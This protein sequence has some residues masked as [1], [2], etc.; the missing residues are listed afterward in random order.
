[1]RLVMRIHRYLSCATA[2]LLLF[3]AVSG[4]WQVFRLQDTK[5]DGSYTAPKPLEVLSRV[6]KVERMG[7]ASATVFKIAILAA[8]TV[9]VT[10]AVLGIVIGIRLTQPR[11]LAWA[12][13]AGGI[14]IPGAL[15][16][17]AL[18][19]PPPPRTPPAAAAPQPADSVAER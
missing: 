12:L 3:L 14:A 7:G 10:T 9:F 2:P 15:A 13:L 8:T 5:K 19:H 16:A 17:Y 4:A 18:A 6:H 11:W 1:M